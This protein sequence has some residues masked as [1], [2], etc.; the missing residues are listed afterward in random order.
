LIPDKTHSCW[1]NLV[2]GKKPIETQ[3][4]GL[5]MILKRQQRHLGASPTEGAL[6]DA[7]GELHAFFAKYESVLGSEIKNL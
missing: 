1:R 2:T 7:I 5:Q 4:L 3:F 6:N